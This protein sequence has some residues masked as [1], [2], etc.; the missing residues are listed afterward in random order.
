MN[1]VSRISDELG[2]IRDLAEAGQ[3]AP[4]LGGRFLT[5]WG[6]LVCLA[7]FGHF[8]IA[9]GALGL[10]PSAFMILWMSIALLGIA[11]QALLSRGL[12]D[13]PGQSSVGNRV[14]SIVWSAAGSLLAV[15]FLSLTV[16]LILSGEGTE[17]FYWS[18]PMALGLY[19]LGQF[20]TGAISGVRTLRYAGI[21]AFAG[22]AVSVFLTGTEFIWLAGSGTTLIAVF[23]PG[24]MM[25]R[26]EPSVN[27]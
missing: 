9:T 1:S 21:V 6:A 12:Q 14:Q 18:V 23:V 22:V 4:L 3:N 13:R 15:F 17:G 7:Y 8:L 5:M 24:V 20:V 10:P 2:Y 25:M 27:V 19:G 26:S 16:R 11:G